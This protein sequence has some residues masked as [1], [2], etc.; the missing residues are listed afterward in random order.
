MKIKPKLISLSITIILMI[1]GGI[2]QFSTNNKTRM[3][4]TVKLKE[5]SSYHE[6][7]IEDKILLN[8]EE[9]YDTYLFYSKM[10]GI[11]M[12]N[13]KKEII[14]TNKESFNVYDLSNNG[15]CYETLDISLLHSFIIT[16]LF[17]V[18]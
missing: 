10:F 18:I 6:I 17:V 4:N 11:S 8:I 12:D 16:F 13:L 9:N 2:I 1:I 5:V 15:T 7:T 3:Q 14:N